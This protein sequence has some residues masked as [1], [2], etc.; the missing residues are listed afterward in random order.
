MDQNILS[1]AL[2]F[3]SHLDF[4]GHHADIAI[5]GDCSHPSKIRSAKSSHSHID[6]Y[7]LNPS[8]VYFTLVLYL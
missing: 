3:H 1:P 5:L 7:T 6:H 4:G 2:V 8:F